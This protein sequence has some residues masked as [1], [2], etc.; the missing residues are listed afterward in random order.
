[1]NVKV[2]L[3]LV[4]I[5]GII[6]GV[7][8]Y[9]YLQTPP[10]NDE[11]IFLYEI[12]FQKRGCGPYGF[13][14]DFHINQNGSATVDSGEGVSTFGISML[15]SGVKSKFHSDLHLGEL[16]FNEI[17]SLLLM[18]NIYSLNERYK[19]KE[20]VYDVCFNKITIAINDVVKTVEY[21]D[22]WGADE[23]T[24]KILFDLAQFFD[25]RVPSEHYG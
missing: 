24:P 20:F 19:E 9:P 22:E 23:S 2:G 1:M 14:Y 8:S 7:A 15:S 13:G 21:S 17:N 16:D 3:I 5:I 10:N 6:I 25:N 18:A 11:Q 12:T 4:L